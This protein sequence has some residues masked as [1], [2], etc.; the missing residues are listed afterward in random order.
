MTDKPK[1]KRRWLQFSLRTLMIVVTVFC[2]LLGTVVKRA[3]DQ[4]QAVEAIRE[5]GGLIVYDYER[6]QRGPPGPEWLRRLAGIDLFAKVV[7][8][9]ADHPSIGGSATMT[10]KEMVHLTLFPDLQSLDL[11]GQNNVTDV[12][13]GHLRGL[14]QLET[15]WLS[16]TNISDDGVAY[17]QKLR[18]LNLL[19]LEGT[20]IGDVGLAKLSDMTS[21]RD[22]YLHNTQITDDGLVHLKG[23]TN[24]QNLDLSGTQISDAGLV[25]LQG[26]KKSN[27]SRFATPQSPMRDCLT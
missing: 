9:S 14:K 21:L 23:I 25:Y 4:R 7:S 19:A 2:I 5:A 17:L 10:D 3:R 24:L 11:Q 22:L 15:L 26:L 18:K 12:G 13:V 27:N 20:K 1:P 8:V 6:D 16:N